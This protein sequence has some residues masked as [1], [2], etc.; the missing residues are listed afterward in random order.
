MSKNFK[1]EMQSYTL[2]F[3]RFVKLLHLYF[4]IRKGLTSASSKKAALARN[5]LVL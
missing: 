2:N 5:F 4:L 3:E 1:T